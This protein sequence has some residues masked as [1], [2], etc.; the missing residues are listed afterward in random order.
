MEEAGRDVAFNPRLD[1]DMWTLLRHMLY[2]PP[3]G[4]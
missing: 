4:K 3:E 2:K 1:D